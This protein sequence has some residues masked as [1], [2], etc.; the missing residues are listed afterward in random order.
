MDKQK[1]VTIFSTPTCPYCVMAKRYLDDKKI[2][3]KN[4]DVSADQVA[5]EKMFARS[6]Q[7][8]VPQLWID[9][10]V[11]VGFDRGRIDEILGLK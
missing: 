1:N 9:D 11:I 10:D 3:Y 5:A 7:M 6:Q 4:I 2:E 8:G